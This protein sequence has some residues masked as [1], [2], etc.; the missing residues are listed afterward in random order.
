[1]RR[2]KYQAK[3]GFSQRRWQEIAMERIGVRCQGS[4]PQK[5]GKA[6][7]WIK[8]WTPGHEGNL[9]YQVFHPLNRGAEDTYTMPG[10]RYESWAIAAALLVNYVPAD[11]VF[12]PFGSC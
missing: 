4:S 7:I 11:K 5:N 3:Q 1:M 2:S 12:L 8:G 10:E 6:T 9:I